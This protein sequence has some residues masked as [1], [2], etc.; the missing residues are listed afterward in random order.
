MIAKV[1]DDAFGESLR[2][3]LEREGV[4]VAAVKSVP[5]CSGIAVIARDPAGENAIVVVAG[6][7]GKLTPADLDENVDLIRSAGIVLCQLE[8][9]LETVEHL[10]A[11]AEKYAVP[12]MLDPAPARSLPRDLLR[13]V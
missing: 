3:G 13:R 12:M 2:Q 7:N 6:A 1:G 11:L 8:V 4:D 10:A 9:P 5:G